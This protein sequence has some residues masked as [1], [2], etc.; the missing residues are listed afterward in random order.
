[1][2]DDSGHN[3]RQ[4]TFSSD[5]PQSQR[6][7]RV[8]IRRSEAGELL[9]AL[10]ITTANGSS[11]NPFRATITN[12]YEITKVFSFVMASHVQYGRHTGIRADR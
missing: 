9:T 7:Q 5:V 10:P 12:L 2:T 4:G 11:R 8:T 3:T 6:H 1:M